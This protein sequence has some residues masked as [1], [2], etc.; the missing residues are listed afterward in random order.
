[1]K[2]TRVGYCG[3]T[4]AN[5]TDR[6]VCSDPAFADWA[7]CVQVE[8]QEAELSY[9]D[10]CRLFF[11]SHESSMGSSKRQYMS[12]IFA[13]T[14][15]QFEI[16]SQVLL[17]VKQGKSR[18]STQVEFA[19]DF[20]DAEYYHQKWLLQRKADWFKRLEMEDPRELVEGEAASRLN[21]YV[22]GHISHDDMKLLAGAWMKDG[23]VSQTAF[24]RI[25]FYL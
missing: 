11:K 6:K 8:Y 17:A 24:E 25:N 18:V 4:T 23:V 15:E 3:G 20:Y 13:H 10:L 19:T 16:A 12:A 21:S 9:E 14:D 1:M 2:V 5:P 7:E 22:A